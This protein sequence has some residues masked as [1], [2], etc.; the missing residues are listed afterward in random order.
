MEMQRMMIE[1]KRREAEDEFLIS[2]SA[3][4]NLYKDEFGDELSEGDSLIIK[5]AISSSA[6]NAP[7]SKESNNHGG[8][9]SL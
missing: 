7:D 8:Y 4:G 9:G 5:K 3:P 6:L 1:Q 2:N